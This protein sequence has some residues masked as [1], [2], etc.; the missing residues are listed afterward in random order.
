MDKKQEKRDISLD[1]SRMLSGSTGVRDVF[2]LF[3]KYMKEAQQLSQEELISMYHGE[4]GGLE[5]PVQIFSLGLSP[6]E[7]LCKYLKENRNFSFKEISDMI[8]RDERSIWNNYQRAISKNKEKI[9]VKAGINVPI[10][11]FEDRQLSIFESLIYYMRENLKMKNKD[12]A[13]LLNKNTSIT[14]TVYKRAL[15]KKNG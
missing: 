4:V 13:K 10:S 2:K 8:K 11:I 15:E 12:V 14:Y 6:S 1:F 5:I 3:L 9:I 7:A